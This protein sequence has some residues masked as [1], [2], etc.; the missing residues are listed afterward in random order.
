MKTT[1]KNL[2][3]INLSEVARG[4]GVTPQYVYMLLA[5]KRQNPKR[6]KQIK[7]AIDNL[8]KAA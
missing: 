2:K 4:I 3:F 1:N 5:G 7:T 8:L 6:L